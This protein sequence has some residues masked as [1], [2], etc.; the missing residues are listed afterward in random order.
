MKL[1]YSELRMCDM[2]F[3]ERHGKDK[4]KLPIKELYERAQE[5]FIEEEG[6]IYFGGYWNETY[7]DDYSSEEWIDLDDL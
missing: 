3:K 6:D 4:V 5:E 2:M 7:N 1:D